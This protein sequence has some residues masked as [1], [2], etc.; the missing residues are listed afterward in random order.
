MEQGKVM[1]DLYFLK[2]TFMPFM[3]YTGKALNLEN[4]MKGKISGSCSLQLIIYGVCGQPRASIISV[5]F[6]SQFLGWPPSRV[7]LL[8][9]YLGLQITIS[10]VSDKGQYILWQPLSHVPGGI[11]NQWMENH[12]TVEGVSVKADKKLMTANFGGVQGTD[13]EGAVL[14]YDT[15]Y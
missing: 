12:L 9:Y 10:S 15:H 14:L 5:L 8:L 7:Y 6:L 13:D 11:L 3:T 4:H 1:R 2:A